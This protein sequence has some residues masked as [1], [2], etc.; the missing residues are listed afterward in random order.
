[1]QISVIVI[2]VSE[3]SRAAMDTRYFIKYCIGDIPSVFLKQ[4]MITNKQGGLKKMIIVI[5]F[6]ALIVVAAG[7]ISLIAYLAELA[8][9]YRYFNQDINRF[10]NR[11]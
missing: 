6:I 3:R 2:S 5:G 8:D 9:D 10:I 4:R 1:M 7:G 11:Y